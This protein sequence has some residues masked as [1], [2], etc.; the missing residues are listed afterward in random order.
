M[1]QGSI[2]VAGLCGSLRKASFNRMALAVFTQRLP[3]GVAVKPV[4]IGAFPLY[5]QEIMEAGVPAAVA[6]ARD[7]I[8]AADAVVIATPEYN[9]STSGVLKNAIDWLSRTTPQPFAA[10]PMALLG[11]SMGMLGTA[12]AQY[13]LRQIMVFLDGRPINRPEVM[14]GAAHTKF[15]PD[16]TLKDEMAVKLITDLG[17][18]LVREVHRHRAAAAAG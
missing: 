6:Q 5:N 17:A 9:Y 13:H 7:T 3:Q 1:S 11:A 14:I 16:G 18:A 8:L 2:T 10:K 15:D 4:E 12:R